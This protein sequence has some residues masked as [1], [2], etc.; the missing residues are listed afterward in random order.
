MGLMQSYQSKYDL[1]PLFIYFC[2]MGDG[3]L[4]CA[5]NLKR[6]A[7]K[8]LPGTIKIKLLAFFVLI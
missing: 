2:S 5:R 4:L 7:C 3:R 8:S 6:D 1:K